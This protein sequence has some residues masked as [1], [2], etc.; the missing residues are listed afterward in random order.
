MPLAELDIFSGSRADEAEVF[1]EEDKSTSRFGRVRLPL[2]L[3]F[4][5]YR[6]DPF[7]SPASDHELDPLDTSPSV[8]DY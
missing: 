8:I 7:S 1:E 2:F 5:S 4:P 6:S 3:V